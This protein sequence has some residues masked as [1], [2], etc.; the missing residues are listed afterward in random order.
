MN[1]VLDSSLRS[2][3]GS[4][5]EEMEKSVSQESDNNPGLIPSCPRTSDRFAHSFPSPEVKASVRYFPKQRN[6]N[7]KYNFKIS[8][9]HIKNELKQVNLSLAT[10]WAQRIETINK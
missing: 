3:G 6:E 5:R 8:N 10:Y 4:W 2:R 9:T 1:T 7:H